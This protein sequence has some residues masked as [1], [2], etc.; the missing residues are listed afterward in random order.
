M[1]M[2]NKYLFKL[3]NI[4]K[5]ESLKPVN[6]PNDEDRFAHLSNGTKT[7]AVTSAIPPPS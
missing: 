5:N 6:H 2:K 7:N 3:N 4:D 1:K